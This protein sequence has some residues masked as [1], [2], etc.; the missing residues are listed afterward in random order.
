MPEVL[1][2]ID[3]V[4]RIK[5]DVE[6]S[7]LRAR[8]GLKHLSGVGR[9]QL[10][11]SP[12]DV[13]W[14]S[15]KAELW[16]YRS[17]RRTQ[18]P[19]LLFVHSLVSR[20]YVFDLAPGNS[21]V[22]AML[23]RGFDVF[24]TEWGEPDEMDAGNTLE[25]YCDGYLPEMVAAVRRASGADEV[26]ILGYCFGG[27]L[28]ML[29]VAGHPG[30]GAR[31]LAVMA[32]PV[33]FTAM[34]PMGAVLQ[35]GKVEPRNLIDPTGNVPADVLRNSFRLL[36]PTADLTSYADLWQNLWSD[37]YVKAH[38]TMTQWGKDHI[39][40]PGACFVQVAELFARQNALACGRVPL[41]DRVV[42]LV[43]ITVPFVSIVGE[44]DHIVPVESS[45]GLAALVGSAEAD[46]LRLPAGHVGLVVGRAAHGRN[47]P[48]I[49][50]WIERHSE[51]R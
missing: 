41:G 23:D 18:H 33:D 47:I 21:F 38:Q 19:P 30:D 3:L 10:G 35:A 28:S 14:S 48:A 15:G 24:L 9:P 2:P 27:V 45:A 22:Q 26:N 46:E 8:N 42:D 5:R 32:T 31:S 6:R 40:F 11:Q 44:K 39:P 25:T 50:G 1:A 17:D 16:R 12:K 51:Q 37:D 7:A 43:D 36:Q 13:V 49:A 29:Y 4:G 34:G 20:S